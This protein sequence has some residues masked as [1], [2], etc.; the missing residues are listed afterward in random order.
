MGV[1]GVGIYSGDFAQDLRASVKAVARLPFS[2]ERLLALLRSAFSPDADDAQSPD[3]TIFWLVAADRFASRGI[4][5]PAARERALQI[6]HDGADLDAMKALGMSDT[7]LRK[8]RAK[9]E[10]LRSRIAAPVESTKPREVLKAPQPLI[11]ATGEVLVYPVCQAEPRNPLLPNHSLLGKDW[12]QDGWGV[13]VVA[14]CGLEFEYLAW[15]RPLVICEILASR[16]TLADMMEPRMWLLRNP[17]TLTARH[18]SKLQLESLGCV[19]IDPTK[20]SHRFP[21]LGSPLSYV[22]GD[23]SIANNLNVRGLGL[24]EAYRIKRGYMPTSQIEA[25]SDVTSPRTPG[26]ASPP[27]R[28]TDPPRVPS[29]G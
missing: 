21:K 2:P 3:Y 23:I 25:L 10:Q 18:T 6:I 8:R 13:F 16:P 20:F 22:V 15:Y 9:L 1:W 26:T 27:G 4:D 29:A 12:V 14:E 24:H 28:K 11:L 19:A 5:C 17:G 7:D